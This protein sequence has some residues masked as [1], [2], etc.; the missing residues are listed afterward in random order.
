MS[1]GPTSPGLTSLWRQ[2]ALDQ[3]LSSST[4]AYI[5]TQSAPM[6]AAAC[7]MLRLTTSMDVVG[8]LGR[9]GRQ[10][11]VVP[12]VPHIGDLDA[13]RGEMPD[14]RSVLFQPACA[15]PVARAAARE[16]DERT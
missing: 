4:A 5:V 14:D 13:V 12:L 1:P 9:L 11:V 16:I 8:R 3:C 15:A 2:G 10:D 7:A 6:T